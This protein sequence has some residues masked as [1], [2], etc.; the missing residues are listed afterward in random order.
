MN[1]IINEQTEINAYD[2]I[3]ITCD[4]V[5]R[6]IETDYIEPILKEIQEHL[7]ENHTS[8]KITKFD[9]DDEYGYQLEIKLSKNVEMYYKLEPIPD[10]INATAQLFKNNYLEFTECYELDLP[11]DNSDNIIDN[12]GDVFEKIAKKAGEI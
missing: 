8:A 7:Q 6:K 12:F 5:L 10:H 11:D 1:T 9:G 4:E 2:K 3:A